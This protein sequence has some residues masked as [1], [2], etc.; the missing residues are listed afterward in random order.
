MY[1]ECHDILDIFSLK[2]AI[3]VYCVLFLMQNSLHIVVLNSWSLAC[4]ACNLLRSHI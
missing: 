1:S 3:Y 2:E 4:H